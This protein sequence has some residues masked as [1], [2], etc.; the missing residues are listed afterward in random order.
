MN[1]NKESV[2]TDEVLSGAGEFSGA[3]SLLVT[4]LNAKTKL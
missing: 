2:V 1:A 4:E 3:K